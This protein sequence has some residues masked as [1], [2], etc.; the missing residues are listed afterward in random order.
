MKKFS[1]LALLLCL[2]AAAALATDFATL[3]PQ[4]YVSDFAQVV[5]PESRAQLERY[6]AALEQSTGVQVALVTL[7]SLDGQP[8]EDVAN[9]MFRKWGVGKK[10]QDNGLLL[11]LSIRDRRSRLEVGYGLEPIITDGDAGDLLRAMRPYLRAERYGDALL[12][13]V[14]ELGT[15]IASRLAP[16][17]GRAGASRAG[18][19]PFS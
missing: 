16:C 12:E 10:G 3:K 11:L 8:V 4:G 5:S 9:D 1:R 18:C 15:K 6:C 13:A 14:N 17:T 19:W 2:A 7:P